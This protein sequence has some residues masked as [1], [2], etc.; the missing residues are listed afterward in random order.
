MRKLDVVISGK[1]PISRKEMIKKIELMGYDYSENVDN[2]TFLII[3]DDLYS[4][5][6]KM[7][8]AKKMIY[9]GNKISIKL[10]NEIFLPEESKIEYRSLN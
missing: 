7:L 5:S 8:K 6:A 4:R 1:M 9:N 10:F 3:T 2:N